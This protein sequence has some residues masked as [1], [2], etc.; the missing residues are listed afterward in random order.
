MAKVL[1]AKQRDERLAQLKAGKPVELLDPCACAK[2]DGKSEDE[3]APSD[4]KKKIK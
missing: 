4:V 2:L 3:D 1:S